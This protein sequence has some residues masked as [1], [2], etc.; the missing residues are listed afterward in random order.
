MNNTLFSKGNQNHKM[1]PK[2][3]VNIKS[4]SITIGL[5]SDILLNRVRENIITINKNLGKL[6]SILNM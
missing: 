4:F 2:E 3:I 6:E 1:K 5:L